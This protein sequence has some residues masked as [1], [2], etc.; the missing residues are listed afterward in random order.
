MSCI[1]TFKLEW[2]CFFFVLRSIFKFVKYV[3]KCLYKHCWNVYRW[4]TYLR[5]VNIETE[6]IL[7][8]VSTTRLWARWTLFRSIENA[9]PSGNRYCLL[10][11]LLFFHCRQVFWKKLFQLKKSGQENLINSSI[12]CKFVVKSNY[13]EA[14][15]ISRW[16]CV[17][18]APVGKN[19]FS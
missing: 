16:F 18:Q 6:T 9:V 11:I 19:V 4:S 1:L 14:S 13:L 17:S 12:I 3:S 2:F 10:R 15:F 8:L 7:R 5:G